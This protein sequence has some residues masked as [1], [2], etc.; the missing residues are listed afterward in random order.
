MIDKQLAQKYYKALLSRDTYYDGV[1]YVGV[2]TTGVFCRSVCPARKPKF[3]NCE[4]FKTAKE[5]VLASFRPCERCKP[6]F[7]PNQVSE[8]VKT[9]VMEVERYPEKR[10]TNKDFEQLSINSATAYRQFKKRFGM[11]FVEYARSRRIGMAMKEIRQGKSVIDAQLGAGYESSSGFRDAVAKII[12]DAPTKAANGRVLKAEWIDTKLGPMVAIADDDELYLLEFVDRRALEREMQR[13]KQRSK[14]PIIPGSSRIIKQIESE[15]ALYFAGKLTEF[16]TPVC[17]I[18]TPF[19]RKV[20]EKLQEIPFGKT[21]S[22]ADLAK[23]IGR[24]TAYRAV[25]N[26][27]GANQFAII[28]PCHRVINNDGKLGGYGGGLARKEWMLNHEK[29]ACLIKKSS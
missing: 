2:K 21:Y 12:G 15:L 18:G 10:W 7:P 28:I 13:L 20:W 26:A 25:A 27:N 19:Q 22:Y 17:L 4:F 29:E 3:E 16:T 8:L 6:L 1:F 24:P 9:L 11:T 5:A 14:L 23:M